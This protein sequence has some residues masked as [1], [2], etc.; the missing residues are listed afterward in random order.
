[1]EFKNLLN[2]FATHLTADNIE[3]FITLTEHLITLGAAVAAGTTNPVGATVDVLST[4][5]SLVAAETAPTPPS[6]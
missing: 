2:T 4:V 6:K 1:M 5:G 3:S